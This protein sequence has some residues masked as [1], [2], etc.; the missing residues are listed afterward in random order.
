MTN[1]TSHKISAMEAASFADKLLR[2]HPNLVERGLLA[3]KTLGQAVELMTA[4]KGGVQ[5]L[6]LIPEEAA[7]RNPS[8]CRELARVFLG[9]VLVQVK[10]TG[11]NC[12]ACEQSPYFP[13]DVI[14]TFYPGQ[15]V[16]EILDRINLL[17][18]RLP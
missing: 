6:P 12:S 18:P 15:K 10:A 4:L 1:E 5:N 2:R 13:P 8:H 9:A 3:T 17:D 7:Q 16:P 11:S 14:D